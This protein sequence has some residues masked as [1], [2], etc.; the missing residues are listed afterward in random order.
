MTDDTGLSSLEIVSIGVTVVAGILLALLAWASVH[1][2][3]L[4]WLAASVGALGG[5]YRLLQRFG[6]PRLVG[7]HCKCLNG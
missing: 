5:Y 4:L 6:G 2:G 7:G 1:N 3:W